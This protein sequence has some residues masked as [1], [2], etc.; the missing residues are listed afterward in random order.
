MRALKNLTAKR[1]RNSAIMYNKT[2]TVKKLNRQ[3][4][5]HE[6]FEEPVKATLGEKM[7]LALCNK[8]VDYAAPLV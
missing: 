4:G 8:S 7:V 3:S 1:D 5:R 6:T 2:Q